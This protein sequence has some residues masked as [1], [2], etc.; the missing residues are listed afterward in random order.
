MNTKSTTDNAF[1]KIVT[2]ML[3]GIGLIYVILVVW[4]IATQDPVT[5]Y[6]K[7]NIKF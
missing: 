4:G 3:L 7:D 2:Y 5:G 1:S 6:I